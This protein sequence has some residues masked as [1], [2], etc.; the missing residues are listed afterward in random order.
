MCQWRLF[1]KAAG[2][3]ASTITSVRVARTTPADQ[4]EGEMLL[5]IA[6]SGWPGQAKLAAKVSASRGTG[7][8]RNG[9]YSMI[10][11]EARTIWFANLK[12]KV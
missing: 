3:K 8:H 1:T 4:L 2:M 11:D 5:K 7:G 9:M 6:H 10:V 12:R